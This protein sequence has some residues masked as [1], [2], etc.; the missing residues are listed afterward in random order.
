MSASSAGGLDVT[1]NGEPRRVAE[2]STVATLLGELDQ[3]PQTVA[4]ERNGSILPR[5]LYASTVLEVGDRLEVVR[6]VQG[7]GAPT[8]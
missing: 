5:R 3:H 4:V 1:L 2:G 8:F 7:G 6:F